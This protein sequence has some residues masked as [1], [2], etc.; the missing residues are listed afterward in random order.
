MSVKLWIKNKLR[1]RKCYKCRSSNVEINQC[2]LC[3]VYCCQSCF[4]IHINSH[5]CSSWKKYMRELKL[6]DICYS[7]YCL[8]CWEEHKQKHKGKPG[9]GIRHDSSGWRGY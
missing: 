5:Q 8:A 9:V 4:N 2:P 3:D 7:N 1:K 6:C